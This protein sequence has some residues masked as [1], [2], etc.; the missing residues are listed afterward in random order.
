MSSKIRP[1]VDV[2]IDITKIIIGIMLLLTGF[3]LAL[4][5]GLWLWRI[6]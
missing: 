6:L 3:I 5:Y 4:K 1:L 2:F